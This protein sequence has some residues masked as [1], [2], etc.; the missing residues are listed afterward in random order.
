[1]IKVK[2]C[3]FFLLSDIFILLFQLTFSSHLLVISLNS[4]V[5]TRPKAN[6]QSHT[7]NNPPRFNAPVWTLTYRVRL[8][9]GKSTLL[10]YLQFLA[11]RPPP[12]PINSGNGHNVAAVIPTFLAATLLRLQVPSR[13]PTTSVPTLSLSTHIKQHPCRL[14]LPVPNLFRHRALTRDFN[15]LDHPK[16]RGHGLDYHRHLRRLLHDVPCHDHD[17]TIIIEFPTT[18]HLFI[19]FRCF[20]CI[21]LSGL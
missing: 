6:R 13:L 8:S 18:P 3:F 9:L 2:S 5:T 15:L 21:S 10:F 20:C 17:S 19:Y 11:H 7:D 16:T 14:R 1:M 12:N 4:L